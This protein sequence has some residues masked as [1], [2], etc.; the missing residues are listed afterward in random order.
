MTGWFHRIGDGLRRTAPLRAWGFVS[1]AF[2]VAWVASITTKPLYAGDT[3]YYAATALRFAGYSRD[4]AYPLVVDYTARYHWATPPPDVLFGYGLTAP[5]LIYPFLSAP[6]VRIFGIGGLSVVPALSLA[7]L[8]ALMF[9]AVAGRFGWR[10]TLVPLILAA[11]STRIVYYMSAELTDGVTTALSAAILLVALRS[12]RLGVRRTAVV[13]VVLTTVMAFTRQAT[14]VPAL[15]FGLA[16][17]ALWARRRDW[18]NRWAVPAL[19]TAATTLVVQVAQSIVWPGFSQLHQLE[20][21]TG[22]ESLLA[23]IKGTPR[24]AYH[25]IRGDLVFFARAD[26]PVLLLIVA[27]CVSVVVLWR[28]E[29]SYLLLGSLVG[30]LVY[31]VSTGVSSGFRY[32]MQSLPYFALSIAALVSWLGA[33]RLQPAAPAYGSG[34][35]G[36]QDH[37]G[38]QQHEAQ[39][40]DQAVPFVEDER[41]RGERED[42]GRGDNHSLDRRVLEPAEESHEPQRGEAVDE[43]TRDDLG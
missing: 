41:G 40:V 39:R 33:A 4:D 5:R 19:A 2:L 11:A 28:R 7:A 8:V 25:V 6:F 18:R 16:W 21:V 37:A 13:L 3:R 36:S 20:K 26:V 24:L 35:A 17:L 1:G 9:I 43:Q 27:G 22:T 38:D 15:A 10:A 30:S 31:N 29:E 14:L 32:E 23:A 12:G 42:Q 34:G